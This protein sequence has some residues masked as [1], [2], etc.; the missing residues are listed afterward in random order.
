MGGRHPG[1]G[2]DHADV[3]YESGYGDIRSRWERK[4]GRLTLEVSVPV[5]TTATV[6]IPASHLRTVTE[7]GRPL[8]KA[9][10][11]SD[12]RFEGGQVVAELGSGTYRFTVKEN[13]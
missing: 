10:G 12:A 11:I 7:R 5:N 8:T 2:L 3:R 1:G 4:H 9:V 6:K 13:A